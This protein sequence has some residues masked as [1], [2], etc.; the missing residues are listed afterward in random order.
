METRTSVNKNLYHFWVIM[1]RPVSLSII[2]YS[3]SQHVDT[4]TIRLCEPLRLTVAQLITTL[5]NQ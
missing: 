5:W 4:V 3:T 1:L 2:I